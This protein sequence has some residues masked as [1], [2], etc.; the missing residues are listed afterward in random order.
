MVLAHSFDE[1]NGTPAYSSP[2]ATGVTNGH[3]GSVDQADLDP[4]ANFLLNNTNSYNKQWALRFSGFT[5]ESVDNFRLWAEHLSGTGEL[6]N[7]RFVDN[8]DR[9]YFKD[10][11]AKT[12]AAP[13]TTLI[14]G[15]SLVPA[16][17][18][19]TSNL[20]G[21]PVTVNGDGTNIFL[22]Q[23]AVGADSYHHGG[24]ATIYIAYDVTS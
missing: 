13:A 9:L 19:G 5:S 16:S 1:Y 2:T 8:T 6:T 4:M 23:V 22:V 15:G 12:T 18:P 3:F 7:N 14:S 24:G 20:G 11:G 21:G 17:K 10:T